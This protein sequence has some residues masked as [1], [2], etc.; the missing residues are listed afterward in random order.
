MN[1]IKIKTMKRRITRL[2]LSKNTLRAKAIQ[3]FL[4][5]NYR[6]YLSPKIS[7]TILSYYFIVAICIIVG[8]TSCHFKNEQEFQSINELQD[9]FV[10]LK[11]DGI[12]RTDS[13]FKKELETQVEEMK[14]EKYKEKILEMLIEWN[15][16]KG[17]DEMVENQLKLLK[18]P[19]KI[20]AIGNYNWLLSYYKTNIGKNE[21]AVK[22]LTEME[23][24]K[25]LEAA[26]A[27]KTNWLLGAIYEE[28]GMDTLAMRHYEKAKEIGAVK[29]DIDYYLE[30]VYHLGNIL[31]N[32]Q[33]I[34]GAEYAYKKAL[35]ESVEYEVRRLIPFGNYHLG[36]IAEKRGDAK[37]ALAFYKESKGYILKILKQPNHFMLNVLNN[38]IGNLQ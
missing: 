27:L 38:K 16:L 4:K 34:N 28:K 7:Q 2:Q 11:Y 26:L 10:K 20:K 35:K 1:A 37:K 30:S 31:Y 8:N 6:K 5:S 25:N 3:A 32:K 33:E 36:K 29:N 17:E 21:E 19:N 18:K 15:L 23:N 12:F 24:N 13:L 14:D 9:K 22:L